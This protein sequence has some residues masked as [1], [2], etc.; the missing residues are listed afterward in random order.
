QQRRAQRHPDLG[1]PTQTESAIHGSQSSNRDQSGA[2]DR[3]SSAGKNRATGEASRSCKDNQQ[4]EGR[5]RFWANPPPIPLAS[6]LIYRR[7]RVGK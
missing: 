1:K 6:N 4:R 5:Q 2:V 3:R 7:F